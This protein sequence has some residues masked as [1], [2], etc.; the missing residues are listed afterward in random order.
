[1]SGY[2]DNGDGRNQSLRQLM[3]RIRRENWLIYSEGPDH[4]GAQP[5]C[6]PPNPIRDGLRRN[7]DLFLSL[8]KDDAEMGEQDKRRILDADPRM[9]FVPPGDWQGAAAALREMSNLE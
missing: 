9:G 5:P 2:G 7:R 6:L 1:M 8:M 3:E 4:L